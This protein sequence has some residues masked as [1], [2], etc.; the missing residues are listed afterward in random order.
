ML[1]SR[2]RCEN[3]DGL[4]RSKARPG[5]KKALEIARVAKYR[6]DKTRQERRNKKDAEGSGI[7]KKCRATK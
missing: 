3:V 4:M 5:M 7:T 1:P 6:D 2:R